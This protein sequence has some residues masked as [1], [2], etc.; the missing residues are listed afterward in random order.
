MN[1]CLVKANPLPRSDLASMDTMDDEQLVATKSVVVLRI[2][3]SK[4]NHFGAQDTF[5][6]S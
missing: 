5:N 4:S 3:N 6:P 1:E 2:G